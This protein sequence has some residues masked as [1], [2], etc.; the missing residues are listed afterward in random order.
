MPMTCP[1]LLSSGPPELPGDTDASNC[2][3]VITYRSMVTVR[4]RADKMPQVRVA[5]NCGPRGLPR[6]MAVSP[7]SVWP[8]LPSSAGSSPKA[9]MWTT[10]TSVWRS[11]A[12]TV[13]SNALPSQVSTEITGSLRS[14]TWAQVRI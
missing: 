5:E 12:T 4:S 14:T 3:R 7:T 13:P 2:R 9:G 8:L 1:R 6:A 10:A 11:S